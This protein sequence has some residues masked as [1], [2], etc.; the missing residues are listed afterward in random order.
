[1]PKVSLRFLRFKKILQSDLFFPLILFYPKICF[2]GEGFLHHYISGRLMDMHSFLSDIW[3]NLKFC[4]IFIH[5]YFLVVLFVFY[6]FL[7]IFLLEHIAKAT[8][9]LV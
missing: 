2:L 1:M 3:R 8:G 6:L 5:G 9:S 4:G 7:F